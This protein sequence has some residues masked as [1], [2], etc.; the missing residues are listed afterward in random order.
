MRISRSVHILAVVNNPTETLRILRTLGTEYSRSLHAVED[1]TEALA[2]LRQ[3][4]I[5]WRV[6]QPDI[7]LFDFDLLKNES[8]ETLAVIRA[9]GRLQAIPIVILMPA[10]S[11]HE[12]LRRFAGYINGFLP[13][14][15]TLEQFTNLLHNLVSSVSADPRHLPH[16]P[17]DVRVQSRN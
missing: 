2:C 8:R 16:D 14:P 13:R 3:E 15:F 17:P 5:F 11:K 12:S 4:G 9:D 6:P 7:V 10:D 1:G